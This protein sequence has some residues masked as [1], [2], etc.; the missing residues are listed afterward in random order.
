M[1]GNPAKRVEDP[2]EEDLLR[3]LAEH[4]SSILIDRGAGGEEAERV[5][6]AT[7]RSGGRLQIW[8]G[9]FAGFAAQI[10]RSGLYIGYDSAGGHV[11]AV[12]GVPLISI[13]GGFVSERMFRRWRPTG[14]GS[15][16][17][18]RAAG[19]GETLAQVT[20]AVSTRIH[21]GGR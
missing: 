18:I 5:E 19:P 21:G 14:D 9:S 7:A 4:E 16:H 17:V 8:D 1:G 10:A 13:F 15:I 3:F 20:E 11:A 12:T 2:F 6:R